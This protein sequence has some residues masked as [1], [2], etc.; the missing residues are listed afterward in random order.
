MAT[1]NFVG[2]TPGQ[3][4]AGFPETVD[5]PEASSQ[6]YTL[7]APVSI[8][9]SGNIAEMATNGT[10]LFGFAAKAGQ[11]GASAGAKT[12]KVYKIAPNARFEGTLS[13]TSWDQSYVGSK[14][15]LQKASSTWIL[16]TL[17]SISSIA[18]AVVLG[19][20]NNSTFA[21]GDSKPQVIFSILHADI[22]GEV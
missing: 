6:T 22:Q 10:L 11:N 13:V 16:A 14:V 20:A 9:A 21:A 19:L 5:V 3:R 1:G 18:Q 12:G 8:D 2:I 15:A 17:T 4:S 7:G